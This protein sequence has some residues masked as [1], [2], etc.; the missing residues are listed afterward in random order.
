L[1]AQSGFW[2][3]VIG[4]FV[5]LVGVV[6]IIVGHQTASKLTKLRNSLAEQT[7]RSKFEESD[8]EGDGK[9]SAEDFQRLTES[10]GMNLSRREREVAFL[11]MDREDKGAITFTDFT[12]WWKDWEGSPNAF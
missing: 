3:F 10:L 6:Y 2:S 12:T 4:G 9:L 5:M 1:I 7:L 11:C 8:K